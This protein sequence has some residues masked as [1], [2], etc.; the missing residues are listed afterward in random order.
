M[1]RNNEKCAARFRNALVTAAIATIVLC[2]GRA[3]AWAA[4]KGMPTP[5]VASTDT[6]TSDRG[7]TSAAT[8]ATAPAGNYADRE[9]S[10]RDLENFKGGDIVIIGSTGAVLVLLVVIL[11][12]LL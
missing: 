10:A 5:P 4:S 12:L 7:T 3:S 11:V 6:G 8:T 2:G 9:T 1:I